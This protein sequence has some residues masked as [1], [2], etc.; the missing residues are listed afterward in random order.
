MAKAGTT[1]YVFDRDLALSLYRDKQLSV[2]RIAK[3]MNVPHD[4]ILR[5]LQRRAGVVMR[6]REE[7]HKLRRLTKCPRCGS[8]LP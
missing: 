5:F 8:P 7:A 1:K 2:Y 3:E 6:T 4:T